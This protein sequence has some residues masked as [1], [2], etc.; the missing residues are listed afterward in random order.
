MAANAFTIVTLLQIRMKVF[1]AVSGTFST[2]P[3]AA[4]ASGCAKRRMM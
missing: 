2:S 4:N 1:S 3:G